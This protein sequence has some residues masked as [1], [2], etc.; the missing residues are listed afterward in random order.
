MYPDKSLS[1]KSG[2]TSEL[3][4]SKCI[5]RLISELFKSQSEFEGFCLDYFPHVQKSFTAGMDKVARVNILLE[6][7]I[8]DLMPIW[9]AL[10]EQF[11][12]HFRDT[13]PGTEEASAADTVAE[14]LQPVAVNHVP[15][16]DTAAAMTPASALPARS[17]SARTLR[18][19]NRV[20][21]I[22]A[23]VVQGRVV[24]SVLLASIVVAMIFCRGALGVA[25]G[26]L[27]LF[28]GANGVAAKIYEYAC[29]TH[30]P[31]SCFRAGQVHERNAAEFRK[32][33]GLMQL[34]EVRVQHDMEENRALYYYD[35]A[36]E[37]I[38]NGESVRRGCEAAAAVKWR[39]I[40]TLTLLDEEKAEER[41]ITF[42][43]RQRACDLGL[44]DACRALG[45]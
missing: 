15:P 25:M 8:N 36:C 12:R 29:T 21:L 17:S 23:D 33:R 31:D 1:R 4:T 6:Y 32:H 39:I 9:L 41:K 5:R 30:N 14:H 18:W 35:I 16:A 13:A 37:S 34:D 27:C 24:V 20:R 19:M 2:H 26:N 11:P 43:Y 22:P 44:L 7:Q 45:K 28:F 38:F 10:R 42:R 40:D 3:L